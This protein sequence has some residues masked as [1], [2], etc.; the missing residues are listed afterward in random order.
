MLLYQKPTK[1]IRVS[2]EDIDNGKRAHVTECMVARAMKRALGVEVMVAFKGAV[3][4]DGS[5]KSFR[6]PDEVAEK[7]LTWDIGAKMEPFSFELD[8]PAFAS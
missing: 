6:L 5:G 7:I 4:T 3:L 1:T 8:I 2:Q